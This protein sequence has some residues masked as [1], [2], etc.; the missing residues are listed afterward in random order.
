M[1]FI[2]SWIFTIF[3]VLIW[4]AFMVAKIHF[5]KFRDYSKYV[6]PVTKVL[7]LVLLILTIVWYYQIYE[8][9]E[10]NMEVQTLKEATVTEVY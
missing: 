9:S 7:S 6:V 3:M 10:L 4:G 2:L 8:Y 5:Y 1:F